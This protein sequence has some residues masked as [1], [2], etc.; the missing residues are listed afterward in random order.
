M[1]FRKCP[2]LPRQWH[3]RSCTGLKNLVV[4]IVVSQLLHNHYCYINVMIRPRRQRNI[5][6]FTVK[7]KEE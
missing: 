2:I 4:E 7:N 6:V 3:S 1:V 5:Y